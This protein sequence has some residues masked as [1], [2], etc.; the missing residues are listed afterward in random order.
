MEAGLHFHGTSPSGWL[1][2]FETNL[3]IIIETIYYEH[4]PALPA[5]G[6]YRFFQVFS[7]GP[8]HFPEKVP[9]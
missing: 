9:K 3:L 5:M 1:E 4:N 8:S 6:G 7:G 2:F